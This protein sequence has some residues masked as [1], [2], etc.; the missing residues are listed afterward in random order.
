MEEVRIRVYHTPSSPTTI[1]TK[2]VWRWHRSRCYMVVG[3]EPHCF[4]IRWENK[5]IWTQHFVRC[6]E[7]SSYCE[8][9]S[10][11]CAVKTEELCRS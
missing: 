9:E 5:K 1:A 3:A 4:G 6:R 7:T 11:D 8:K 2:R 10:A